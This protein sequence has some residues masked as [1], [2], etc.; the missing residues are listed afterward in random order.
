MKVFL[1]IDIEG[2]NGICSWDETEA[3]HPRYREFKEQLQ[4]EVSAACR[5]AI[6]AGATEIVVKD[7]HDS[8]R[9]LS[10]LDLPK[11]VKLL[12]GWEGCPCSMM[13]G[14][15]STYDAVIFILYD[16]KEQ[17]VL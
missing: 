13:A 6:K 16:D 1:S 11:E 15:D 2:V 3:N 10:I 7:A 17:F 5:G 14:L 12:R 4:R 8:A 9:N